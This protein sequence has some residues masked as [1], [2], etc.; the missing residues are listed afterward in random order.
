MNLIQLILQS[1]ITVRELSPEDLISLKKVF[2]DMFIDIYRACQKHG[3]HVMLSGGCCLGAVRHNGFIP[4]DDDMD[5]MLMRNDYK[6]LPKIL[7]TEYGNKYQ[8]VGPNISKNTDMPFM[9]IEKTG[10][11]LRSIYDKPNQETPIFIDA[12][13]IDNIPD[14]KLIRYFNAFVADGLYYIAL[15]I[16]YYN[17]RECPFTRILYSTKEG[18]KEIKRR[19]FIGRICSIVTSH[20]KLFN[21][22][23][24][25]ISRH[26]NTTKEVGV[27]CSRRYLR[28]I[29]PR[30]I[31]FPTLNYPF[32]NII[33][34]IPQNFDTYLTVLYGDYMKI[35][36]LEKRE[37]H[38]IIDL[39]I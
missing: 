18:K 34:P 25:F 4:W 29:Y 20:T 5:I 10:T 28:E 21:L 8:C 17:Y 35:P 30:N 11:L 7:F 22:Y 36:P 19:L 33:A 23:D 9:H 24:K 26:S 1:G 37:K 31:F 12:F 3:I 32:E 16:K 13:P 39:K 2:I 15:C 6:R 38:Y 27:P 14:N